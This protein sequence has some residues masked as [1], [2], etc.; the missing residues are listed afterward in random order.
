MV[1]KGIILSIF[2]ASLAVYFLVTSEAVMAMLAGV[3]LGANLACVV[4][5][6]GRTRR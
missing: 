6:T 1:T 2:S 3:M 5:N 4:I